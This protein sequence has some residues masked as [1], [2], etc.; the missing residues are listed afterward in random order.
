MG[1]RPRKLADMTDVSNISA[2]R[3]SRSHQSFTY[4]SWAE[5]NPPEEDWKFAISPCFLDFDFMKKCELFEGPELIYLNIREM[6]S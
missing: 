1:F 4:Q 5:E 6:A 3:D 2:D